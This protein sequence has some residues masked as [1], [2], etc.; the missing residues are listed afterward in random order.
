MNGMINTSQDNF[1]NKLDRIFQE[2]KSITDFSSAYLKYVGTVLSGISVDE[3]ALFVDVLMAA[4]EK[5]NFIY[6]IGNTPRIYDGIRPDTSVSG[7]VLVC[8]AI[9][10]S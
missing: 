6:F 1:M 10:V 8:T 7:C 3:I 4:R 5:G 2:N 9:T